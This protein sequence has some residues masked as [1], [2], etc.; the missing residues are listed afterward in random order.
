M[1]QCAVAVAAL[2]VLAGC[3]PGHVKLGGD[4]RPSDAEADGM[5]DQYRKLR[6]C[7]PA[8]QP[9]RA[10]SPP[11]PQNETSGEPAAPGEAVPL[12]LAGGLAVPA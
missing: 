11:A 1:S 12:M 8:A 10:R 2:I 7:P 3:L 4:L 5:I 6:L 9:G